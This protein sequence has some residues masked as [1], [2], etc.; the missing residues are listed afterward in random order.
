VTEP[1]EAI[2]FKRTHVIVAV[3]LPVSYAAYLCVVAYLRVPAVHEMLLETAMP[4]PL[5]GATLLLLHTYRY[6]AV[7]VVGLAAA[8]VHFAIRETPGPWHA[9]GL[10]AASTAAALGLHALL[11]EGCMLPIVRLIESLSAPA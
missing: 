2:E 3:C 5:P 9:I 10:F 11:I 7:V 6:W 4:A 8:T 1:P